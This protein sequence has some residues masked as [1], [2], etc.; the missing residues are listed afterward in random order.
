MAEAHFEEMSVP[1]P[2][3]DEV[4][5]EFDTIE[6][7]F[8]G[9]DFD[10]AIQRWDALRRRLSTYRAIA[11]LKFVQNTR[12][13]DARAER[14]FADEFFPR[15]AELET[16]FKQ[17]LIEQATDV[18]SIVGPHVFE[19][20]RADIATFDP[21]IEQDLVTESKT[22]SE[23]TDIMSSAEIEFEG[24]TYNLSQIHRFVMDPD[25]DVRHRAEL[26]RWS[27]FAKHGEEFDDIYD[28]LVRL[29]HGMAK[30]LGMENYVP[31]G[32]LRRQRIDYDAADVAR[33]RQEV[34]DQVVPLAAAIVQRQADVLGVDRVMKWDE[35]V[36]D[37]EGSPQPQGG[38]DD[39]V[40]SAHEMFDA[41]HPKLG[42]FFATM[43]RRGLMDLETRPGKSTGGFCTSF[44]EYGVPFIFANFNG[45]K[46]DVEV[47]THEMGHAFQCYV[48]MDKFPVDLIWPTLES[49][50]I[51]SMSLEFLC[52]PHMELFFGD[53]AE[54]FRRVHLAESLLFLPY[55]C[56]VDEFQH[57]VFEQPDATPD[58]R[59][60]IWARLEK[61]YMPWRDWGDVEHGANGGRWHA[62]SHVF[63][64]PFYYIDYVLA[65]TCALQFWDRM[66]REPEQAMQD[67]V[68]LCERG[69][70]APFLDLARS[71]GLTSPFEE[72]CL[73]DAAGRARAYLGL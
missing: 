61:K 2:S 60:A 26:A 47:F 23:Y 5:A 10:S 28:R 14:E 48:S 34:V 54:R 6:H 27:W 13:D 18:E 30:K 36:F 11:R 19:L 57:R 63:G 15:I 12:D 73:Q 68:A 46:G 16:T 65:M 33:F 1:R 32:Y 4:A 20:W 52:W 40:A 62:Q 56:L 64:N 45:T 38:S 70:E 51:H 58:E 31:L 7:A 22:T 67:Y 8:G 3:F 9:G 55:G 24:E 39:L 41:M 43:D 72:G 44:E 50:E 35:A 71:A 42:D 59:R 66:N 25:R 17:R 29:R 53:D 69:G 37:P 21:S 49:C